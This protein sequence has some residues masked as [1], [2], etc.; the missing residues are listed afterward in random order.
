M[1]AEKSGLSAEFIEKAESQPAPSFLFSLATGVH[2]GGFPILYQ[3]D[4]PIGDKAF[5][6]QA[7]VIKDVASKGNCVVVG[8]CSRYILRDH[9]GLISVF[10]YADLSSRVQRAMDEYGLAAEKL[11]ER[12][13]KMDKSRSDYFRYYTGEKWDDLRG[14][15][16]V[17]N[18]GKVGIDGA[19]DTIMSYLQDVQ[20]AS[21]K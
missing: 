2:A 17:I 8:R 11:A 9:P 12:I 21:G 18:T 1:A 20:K 19:V 14:Y 15:D 16:L 6:A 5:Y 7:E 3:Y 4:A 13:R 10:L